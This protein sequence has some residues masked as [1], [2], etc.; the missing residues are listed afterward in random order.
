MD[1]CLTPSCFLSQIIIP[2]TQE[3]RHQEGHQT[4]EGGGSQEAYGGHQEEVHSQS[5]EGCDTQGI[6]AS[7]YPLVT[8]QL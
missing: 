4:Q 2:G 1:L 5:Q 7:V 3:D 8:L 6:S